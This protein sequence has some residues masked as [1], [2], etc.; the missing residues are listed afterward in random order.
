MEATTF[1]DPAVAALLDKF[2]VFKIDV[3]AVNKNTKQLMS[4]FGVIAPPT[5]I[6]F[7]PQGD[8]LSDS[9]Q[10]GELST[11]SFSRY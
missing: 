3:S 4:H 6:F 2:A 8:L 5:F 10:V 1:K 9:E 7:S 11:S